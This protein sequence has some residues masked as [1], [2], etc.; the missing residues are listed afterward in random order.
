MKKT[1]FAVLLALV[2]VLALA[3]VPARADEV[4]VV[5]VNYNDKPFGYL[6]DNGELT[7]FTV[8]LARALC[9][10]MHRECR[11]YPAVFADLLPGVIDGRYDFVVGNLLRTPEREKQVDFTHRLWRSSSSFAGKAGLSVAPTRESLKGKTIAVQKGAIQ[12][13][14]LHEYFEDVATIKSY[15]TNIERNAALAEGLADLS[16]GSTVSHFAFLTSEPGKGFD[17]VSGPIFDHGLGG[18]VA[19]PLRKGRNDL[20]KHLNQAIDTILRDGTYGRI[21][22]TYFKANVF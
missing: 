2:L 3:H 6:N 16:F 12:E 19:I 8:D 11:L 7:G 21:I 22:N 1:L 18:E 4:L 20:R 14:Y 5:A 9:Q 10:A 17:I 13:K 15:P